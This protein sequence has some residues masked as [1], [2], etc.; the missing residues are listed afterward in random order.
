MPDIPIP[1]YESAYIL[2]FGFI[3]IEEPIPNDRRIPPSRRLDGRPMT[4]EEYDNLQRRPPP[5]NS[6][7]KTGPL[8]QDPIGPPRPRRRAEAEEIIIPRP[9]PRYEGPPR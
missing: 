9:P 1:P 8:P 6:S 5:R 2:P 3:P 7:F 4:Q